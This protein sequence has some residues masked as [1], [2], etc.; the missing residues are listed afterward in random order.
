M[1]LSSDSQN[2]RSYGQRATAMP[3]KSFEET[4][5]NDHYEKESLIEIG[6]ACRAYRRVRR[7]EMVQGHHLVMV[8][9]DFAI[10]D[11]CGVL[12]CRAYHRFRFRMDL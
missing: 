8:V 3:P 7:L 6:M 5:K 10:V 4:F 11:A 12:G 1:A 9:G 2:T